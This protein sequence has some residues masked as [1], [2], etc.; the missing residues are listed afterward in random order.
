MPNGLGDLGGSS[1]R[2]TGRLT[3]RDA[4]RTLGLTGLGLTLLSAC[5]QPAAGT[6]PAAAP[7]GA[8][9]SAPAAPA[10]QPAAAAKPAGA[11][12]K[13][14]GTLRFYL[15]PENPPTLDPYLNIS[16]R[17]QE[18]AAFF[19]SRLIMP[20]KGPGIPGL[21]YVFEGDLAES[22]QS[23]PD[24]KTWTFTL[25]PDIKFHNKPPVNGRP[26][27]AQDVV[28][29]FER[30]IKLSPQRATFD[31][32]DKVTAPDDRTVVFQLKDVYAPFESAVGAPYLWILPHEVVDKDG[33]A[34]KTVVGSG[35]FVFDKYESGVGIYGKKNPTFH[36]KGEPHVDA[37]EAYTIPDQAT[38]M[39][40]L[41]AKELDFAE[42]EQQDLE[43][44]KQT[45]PD[46]QNVEVE[47][48]SNV[49]I[50]FKVDKPPFNDV[51]VRQAFAMGINRDEMLTTVFAGRGGFS[52]AIP[53]ALTSWHLDPRGPD[54]GPNAKYFK[55]NPVE[56]KQLLAA[57]G[58]PDGMKIKLVST[59][60][61]GQRV[62]QLAE[63]VQQGLKSIGVEANIEMQE[64][65]AYIS[66]TF[67]GKFEGGNVINVGPQGNFNEP[68]EF[69]LQMYHPKGARNSNNVNDPKLTEM[70]DKEVR[71]LD[72]VDRKK[73]IDDIQ[74]YLA[75]QM[76]YIPTA[77]GFRSMLYQA[78]VRDA[79]PRS[80]F[81]LGAEVVPK[82]WFDK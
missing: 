82:L 74:R 23:S 73:Q 72:K 12:P 4:L 10:G 42:V 20:K 13:D 64:Y 7:A 8:P 79:Y 39:A 19:Y 60:G 69:L 52:T 21:A 53:F 47:F 31:V 29:S 15:A 32:V 75:E 43:S 17:T 77:S 1:V 37:F 62:V 5:G 30:F 22:W 80:D 2:P 11:T 9:A 57:A 40:S 33:D 14:G 54:F 59:P 3:R 71:T 35:P 41:R 68:H 50:Y 56:A 27:V 65:A 25:K 24:G 16:V 66:T 38:R 48:N 67:L 49:N 6:K 70:I 28:W 18:P 26:L 51:R 63:L 45:N 44:L 81:G 34:A 55:Y 46:M 61:Y 76:Y 58:F 78:Y 36:R